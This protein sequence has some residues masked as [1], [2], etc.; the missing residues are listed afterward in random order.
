MDINTVI[1]GLVF[2]ILMGCLLGLNI[3]GRNS[4][5][6]CEEISTSVKHGYLVPDATGHGSRLKC[7]GTYIPH[8]APA[9]V[10]Y[11][12]SFFG[13]E[14]EIDINPLYIEEDELKSASNKN[15]AQG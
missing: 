3:V 15:I 1:M 7:N 10:I 12:R 4:S 13:P 14:G 9:P 11:C 8:P 6:Y 2:I 5:K